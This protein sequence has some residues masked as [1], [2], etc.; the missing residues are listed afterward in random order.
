M[1]R[2]RSKVREEHRRREHAS[3]FVSNAVIDHLSVMSQALSVLPL[4]VSYMRYGHIDRSGATG[5]EKSTL[6][7]AGGEKS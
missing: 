6:E 1:D 5:G 4:L 2:Q 3:F 7:R